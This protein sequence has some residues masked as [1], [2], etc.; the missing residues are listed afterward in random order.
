MQRGRLHLEAA[1]HSL[2]ADN[3]LPYQISE[4]QPL[5]GSGSIEAEPTLA[6]SR[7]SLAIMFCTVSVLFMNCALNGLVTLNIPQL[8]LEFALD[9]G[10][11]LW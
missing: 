5:L 8:S 1:S 7:R 10:V 2:E 4:D 9:P 6:E 11:E 3:D